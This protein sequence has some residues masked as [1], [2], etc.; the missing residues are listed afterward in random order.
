MQAEQRSIEEGAWG[1]RAR[2]L[3]IG[4]LLACGVV[5]ALLLG[6]WPR[7]ARLPVD[8]VSYTAAADGM[9][10]SVVVQHG[11]C[12]DDLRVDVTET[13]QRVTLFASLRSPGGQA[14]TAAL[15]STIVD[16]VLKDP[17]GGR[18]VVDGAH[19]DRPLAAAT[20]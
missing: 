16:V 10:L 19:Q 4:L 15:R 12:G 8:A 17:L 20:P 13:S 14:C 3:I 2:L 9:H 5:V 11:A 18:E 1:A 6:L 7:H